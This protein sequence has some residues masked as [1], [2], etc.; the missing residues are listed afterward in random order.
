MEYLAM[1][2]FTLRLSLCC[3]LVIALTQQ[4]AAQEWTRFH[5][6][7]GLGA[8]ET[9][10]IPV[11]WS[12]ADYNW[13]T[14]L[15]GVGHSQPVFWANKIFLTSA[16]DDGAKRLVQCV[17]ATDGSILWQKV[18]SYGSNRMH[19]FNSHASSTPTVDSEHVYVTFAD[20]DSYDLYALTH[21]GDQRAE[22]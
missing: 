10:G 8:S 7:N 21:H 15:D 17:N 12:K 13:K 2:S 3:C 6:T 18:F 22:T 4:L 5:G 11:K 14:K 16:L 1:R 20:S 9:K 19:R